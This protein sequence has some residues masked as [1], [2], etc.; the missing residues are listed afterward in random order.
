MVILDTSVLIDFFADRETPHTRWLRQQILARRLGITSLVEMEVLQ[1]IQSDIFLVEAQAALKAFLV[2]ETGSRE[3]AISAAQNFRALRKIGITI[4]SSIDCL[5]AT[6]CIEQQ[7]E[8]L[9]TD[10]NFDPF[11]KYLGLRVIHPPASPLH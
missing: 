6:F 10:R 1:G 8:L 7:H 11:E 2:F 5:I 4:R 9:H 3:I